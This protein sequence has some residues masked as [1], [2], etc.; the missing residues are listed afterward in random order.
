M[1]LF[2]VLALCGLAT[3]FVACDDGDRALGPQPTAVVRYV[4]AIPDTMALDFRVIDVLTDAPNG[5]GLRFRDF[6]HYQQVQAGTRRIRVFLSDT[7]I[8]VASTVVF[9]EEF[10]FEEG[11][12]YTVVTHGY[13]RPGATPQKA[14]SL[15]EDDSPTPGD[16]QFAIRAINLG[17]TLGAVD[18]YIFPQAATALPAQPTVSGLAVGQRSTYGTDPVGLRRVTVTPAGSTTPLVSVDAPAGA[19]PTQVSSALGGT[20]T[21][22]SALTA[23]LVPASVAGDN[24]NKFRPPA[25]ATPTVIFLVDRRRGPLP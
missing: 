19:A 13:A 14:I 16:G 17:G 5:V 7:A 22:G 23:L 3:A 12:R 4:N 8:A 21:Q 20:N 9:E 15:I 18:A 1:K 25:Y 2:R 10:N 6:T 24:S 11:K